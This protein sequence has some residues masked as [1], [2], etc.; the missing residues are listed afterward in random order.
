MARSGQIS[1]VESL[2]VEATPVSGNSGWWW[3]FAAWVIAL[4]ATLAALF[5]GEILGQEPCLLCWYQRIAMFPLALILGIA[6]MINDTSVPRYA[7][8]LAMAGMAVA[9]WH[10][11]LY[12]EVV[13]TAIIPCSAEGPSCTGTAMTILGGVPLPVI[14]LACFLVISILLFLVPATK[15]NE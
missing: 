9:L 8:P 7:L 14:S 15:R 2:T 13:S 12:A 1:A 5:I 6:V 10:T 3:L 11:L 4:A